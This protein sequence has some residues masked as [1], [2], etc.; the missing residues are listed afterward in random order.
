LCFE[1]LALLANGRQWYMS[2]PAMPNAAFIKDVLL[3]ITPS[4]R[5]FLAFFTSP[6]FLSEGVLHWLKGEFPRKN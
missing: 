4:G 5:Y 6:N 2:W 3:D 1:T